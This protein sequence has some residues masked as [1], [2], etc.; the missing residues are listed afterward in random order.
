[1]EAGT[2]VKAT[3]SANVRNDMAIAQEEIFGP[4]LVMISYSNIEEVIEITNDVEYGLHAY[5]CGSDLMAA[6]AV[7]R[8]I[9]AGWVMINELVDYPR[10]PFEGFK[11]SGFGREFGVTGRQ[12]FTE[13]RAIFGL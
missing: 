9:L 12:A 5:V 10:A 8:R 3:L 4:V 11:M 13:P 1:M 6:G 2:F 7:A